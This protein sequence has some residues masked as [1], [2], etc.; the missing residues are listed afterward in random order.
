MA[1]MD[2]PAETLPVLGATAFVAVMPVPASP[3]GGQKGMP[4]GR[5]PPRYSLPLSVSL[6]ASSPA[7]LTTGRTLRTFHGR[8]YGSSSSLNFVSIR[9]S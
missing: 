2:V 7:I 3:S 4:A 5:R 8:P 1:K 6:P 9:S